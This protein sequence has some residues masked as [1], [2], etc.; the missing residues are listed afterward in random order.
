MSTSM[1]V[2]MIFLVV[3]NKTSR[4][5]S[6]FHQKKKKLPGHYVDAPGDEAGPSSY[7]AVYWAFAPSKHVFSAHSVYLY[8]LFI[9]WA[10]LGSLGRPNRGGLVVAQV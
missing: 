10:R 6:Y 5:F 1:S 8:G 9:D 7:W 4:T 2:R 3:T